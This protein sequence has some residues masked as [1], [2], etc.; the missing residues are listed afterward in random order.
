M[1]KFLFLTLATIMGCGVGIEDTR[2]HAENY[3]REYVRNNYPPNT[4]RHTQ[5]SGVDTDNNG[6]VTCVLSF[7][8]VDRPPAQVECTANWIFEWDKVCRPYRLRTFDVQQQ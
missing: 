5:C 6:Y 7:V 4:V 8:N 2:I 1:K 3:V